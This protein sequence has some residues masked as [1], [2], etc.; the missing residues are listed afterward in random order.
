MFPL[1][2]DLRG[3]RPVE[4]ACLRESYAAGS[5]C[6]LLGLHRHGAAGGGEPARRRGRHH[7]LCRSSNLL[8]RHDAKVLL[9]PERILTAPGEGGRI[10]T[11]GGSSAW[12]RRRSHHS[13]FRRGNGQKSC[14]FQIDRYISAA[15]RRPVPKF[16]GSGPAVRVI[17]IARAAKVR[18]SSTWS[19]CGLPSDEAL[20]AGQRNAGRERHGESDRKTG[21]KDYVPE[22]QG[23]GSRQV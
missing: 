23:Q 13:R 22:N 6:G 18:R 7:A 10:A 15:S 20:A 21:D 11:S 2:P 9:A 1:G 8:N 14:F 4:T 5:T 19:C 17:P 16:G 3:Q 12:K